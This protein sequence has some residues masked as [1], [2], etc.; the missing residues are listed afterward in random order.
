M[1]KEDFLQIFKSGFH[2]LTLKKMVKVKDN[3][4]EHGR[5]YEDYLGLF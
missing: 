1:T 3:V 2:K 5:K 4:N